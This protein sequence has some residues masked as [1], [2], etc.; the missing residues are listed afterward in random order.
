MRTRA[1]SR[2]L[3]LAMI[4]PNIPESMSLDQQ[5]AEQPI[6]S[7]ALPYQLRRNGAPRYRCGTRG[8]SNCS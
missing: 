6:T 5:D 1:P 2:T 4:L 3:E 8:S 7:Q